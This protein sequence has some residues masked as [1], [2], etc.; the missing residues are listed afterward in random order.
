MSV[1][2]GRAG[3]A[4]WLWTIAQKT[5]SASSVS[6]VSRRRSSASIS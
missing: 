4:T 2:D 6:I 5:S 3:D 1:G